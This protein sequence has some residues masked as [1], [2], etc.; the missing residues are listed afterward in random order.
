MKTTILP[1][2]ITFMADKRSYNSPT[3]PPPPPPDIMSSFSTAL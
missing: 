2:K 1:L 3:P